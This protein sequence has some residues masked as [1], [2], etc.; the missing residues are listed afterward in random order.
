MG[1]NVARIGDIGEGICCEN[2]DHDA[3][4]IILQGSPNV[5]ANG[6]SVARLGDIVISTSCG[7]ERIGTIIQGSPTVNANGLSV[8]RIGDIF[9]GCF[10]GTIIGGSENVFA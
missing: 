4:G 3:T 7:H 6:L 9:D 5:N 1:I 8:A 10:S 2:D